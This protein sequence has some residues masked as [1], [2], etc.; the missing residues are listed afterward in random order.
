MSRKTFTE[1]ELR[2]RLTPQQYEVT[3]RAG[4]EPAF[5]G[6]YYD[7][8]DDGVYRCVVCDE[9]LFSSET[10]YDSGSGWP[11]FYQPIDPAKV[12][13]HEDRSYG[14]VR[15]EAACATCGAHLGHIFP[16]GPRPTGQ[17]YCLNSASLA[18]DANSQD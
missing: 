3:Q 9:E 8:K 5:S 7:A 13:T 15:T 6:I 10:K 17:R 14:M 18:L 1:E 11:S 2:E 12:E 16:D 4:T